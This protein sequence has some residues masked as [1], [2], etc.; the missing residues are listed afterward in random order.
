MPNWLDSE[1]TTVCDVLRSAGYA[2][3]HF[4]KWHLGNG[5]GAPGPGDYGV[6]DHRTLVSPEPGWDVS[7]DPYFWAHSTGLFVDETIRFIKKSASEGKPFY[8]N[9]WTL[10]PHA[11]LKPTP[12]ELAVYEGLVVSPLRFESY[13]RGYVAEAEDMNAQLRVFSAAMTGLDR[14]IGRLLDF[15]DEAGLAEN[16][17]LFF[18][19]DNGPEDYHIGNAKNAGMGS[20]GHLRA[21][22]RSIYEG[23]VRVPFIVRWPG[24]VEARRVDGNSV[25]TAV[26]FLPT[27]CSLAGIAMPDAHPDG[28]DVADILAG[29]SRPRG[30]PIF[31]EWR[32][33]VFGD[34]EYAPPPLAVRE[35]DW[36]LFTSFDGETVELYNIPK[37][38]EERSN[39]ADEHPETVEG[40]RKMAL[41]WKRGLP[42]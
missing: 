8:V 33:K 36:K 27:V 42:E 17:V 6:D 12:E 14:E 1:V 39:V 3:A 13:M 2:T 23:G 24:E 34:P 32:F 40:L 37:D 30:K 11:T 18:A 19:S 29:T 20:P 41:D 5:E 21:R 4:G 28:E 25:L 26:D 10:V 38:P 7:A 22:K 35:G 31:W 16:T 9:L 15:L